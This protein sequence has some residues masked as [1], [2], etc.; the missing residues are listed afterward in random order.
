MT[1]QNPENAPS[2]SN[3]NEIP[4]SFPSWSPRRV[5]TATLVILLAIFSFW[6]LYRFRL[7]VFG[8]FEAVVFSTA[9]RPIVD[10]MQ[11]R[12][13]PRPAGAAFVFV[14]I[15]TLLAGM[16]LLVLP[17]F[18]QQGSNILNTLLE[19]Y[20]DLRSWLLTSTSILVRRIALR[21]PGALEAAPPV[22][23][24]GDAPLDQVAVVFSYA[25]SF[26]GG[27]FVT[28]TVLLL[29]FYWTIDRERILFSMLMFLPVA[30]R[31]PARNFIEA[32]EEKVGA[33]LRGLGIMCLAIGLLSL[34][35]Y[36]IIGLPYTPLL[37]LLAGLMEAVPLI[38]PFLGAVPAVLITLALD[39]SKVIW[40]I[41]ATVVI[42]V[43]ENNLLVPRVMDRSVGVNPVVSL[44]AFVSFSS[45][46][47]LA[48]ALLAIPLAAMLQMIFNRLMLEPS[49]GVS[50]PPAGRDALS[51]LRYEAQELIQ[52]VRK[53][54]RE[55]HTGLEDPSEQIEDAIEA[56]VDDL[57]SILADA[58][59]NELRD[60]AQKAAA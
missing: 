38:G 47:G 60:S 23:V 46:F 10:W 16:V 42:Q 54:V 26:V 56:I 37:A 17:L 5:I 43:L 41:A 51:L 8:V 45:L 33:Y 2:L 6:L 13:I 55:K 22:P 4:L 15:L 31:E 48:G 35:A 9:V 49:A 58:E 59:Q 39:P 36:L 19:Y 30:R 25:S 52:D 1:A 57:D 11:R 12:G 14:L 24:Q 34:I 21:L 40:V 50:T 27:L 3:G 18:T 32:T 20:T 53:Q 44:L 7:V 28:L 29:T